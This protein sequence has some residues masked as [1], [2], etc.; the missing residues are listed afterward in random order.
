MAQTFSKHSRSPFDSGCYTHK[1]ADP[2]TSTTSCTTPGISRYSRN[3]LPT[4]SEPIQPYR[5]VPANWDRPPTGTVTLGACDQ[6]HSKR[7]CSTKPS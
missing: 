6:I 4:I 2:V 5:L 7:A 3:R 1:S